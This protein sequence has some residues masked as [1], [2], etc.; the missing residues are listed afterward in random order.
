MK[1]SLESSASAATILGTALS[2]LALVQS[3]AWLVLTSLVLVGVSLIALVYARR[4]R[5]AID[6]AS[7]VIEGH[8]IDCLNIA[9]LRRRVNRT[10]VIQEA[11]HTVRIEGGDLKITWKYS[12]YCRADRESAMEFSVDSDINTPFETMNCVAYDLGRDPGMTQK[13]RPLLVGAKGISKKISVPFLEPLKAEQPFSLLLS[14]TLP[15]CITPGFGYYTSTLSFAQQKI[16]RCVVRLVF[17]GENPEWVRVYECTSPGKT[18]L[19]K[20]LAASG[21]P[22]AS[23]EYIDSVEDRPGQSTKIYAFWRHAV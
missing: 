4:D 12:G 17:I 6:A 10:F 16:R 8:S 15:R 2:A 3:R 19:L 5:L 9:N 21:P 7:V 20:S 11:E 13:I 23:W 14:F 22:E 1:I 18:M